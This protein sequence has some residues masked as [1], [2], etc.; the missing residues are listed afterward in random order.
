MK[1]LKTIIKDELR[2]GE[3]IFITTKTRF[4][5]PNNGEWWKMYEY[6]FDELFN[7]YTGKERVF[8][9]WHEDGLCII[10]DK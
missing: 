8:K 9:Y 3:N 4:N 7:L 10:L 6:T 1:Y 2:N 5:D